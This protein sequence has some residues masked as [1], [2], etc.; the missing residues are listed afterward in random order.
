VG[1][2]DPGRR[3]LEF[4]S[5][6]GIPGARIHPRLPTG[7]VSVALDPEGMPSFTIHGDCAWADLGG[8]VAADGARDLDRPEVLVFGGLAMHAEGNRRLLAA[9]V[10]AWAAN[11]KRAPVLLCDLNLRPGWSDPDVARW[12]LEQADYLKVNQEEAEFLAGLEA[13]EDPEAWRGLLA[14]YHLKGACITRG[15]EGLAWVD[16]H[17]AGWALPVWGEDQGAPPVVDTLGAGDAVTAA[18]ASGL[19]TG[20]EPERFLELGSRWAARTCAVRGALPDREP[21][22]D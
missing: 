1:Q 7:S 14:R 2:D 4:L 15:P 9:L 22:P 3:A 11:G 6:E 8:A 18:V 17:G 16:P 19:R 20:E 10:A 12:C 13:R 21:G 5:Q